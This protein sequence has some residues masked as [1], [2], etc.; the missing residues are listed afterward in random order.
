[1]SLYILDT[2]TLTLFQHGHA[3]VTSRC[4]AC[5]PGELA[6]TVISVEE[7]LDGRFTSIRRSRRSDDIA[8]AYQRLID[9][10]L[11]LARMPILPFTPP[12]IARFQHLAAMKLNVGRI[13]LRIAATAL[14]VS[15]T[16][17]TRNRRDFG[18]IPGLPI[19]DWSV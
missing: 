2:D 18:R 1:M 16:V 6:I 13:D 9:S 11:F 17:V 10:L 8:V 3:I 19:E 14:E 5:P 7:Q 12:M 4:A 15:A